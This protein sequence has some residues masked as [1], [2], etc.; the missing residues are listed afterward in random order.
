MCHIECAEE[1]PSTLLSDDSINSDAIT[2]LLPHTMDEWEL[3]SQMRPGNKIQVN[4]LEIIG[5]HEFD[6]NHN[7][8]HNNIPTHLH[9]TT[10]SFID[11][12]HLSIQLHEDIPSFFNSPNSLS[13]TQRIAFDLVMSHFRNTRYAQLL[14]LMIQTLMLL[15]FCYPIPWMNGNLSLK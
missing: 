2:F 4:D 3:L 11:L 6:K 5:H 15:P 9:E 14:K 12:N 1:E 10:T 13:P 7:W 8:S